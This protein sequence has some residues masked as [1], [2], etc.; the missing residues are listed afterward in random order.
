MALHDI[1]CHAHSHKHKHAVHGHVCVSVC[2]YQWEIEFL[3]HSKAYKYN[4][5]FLV[6]IKGLNGFIFTE[7]IIILILLNVTSH[8][9]VC[10]SASV[11]NRLR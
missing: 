1:Q 2:A 5:K 6:G 7:I 3:G 9:I 10:Y 8:N 11:D 4:Q